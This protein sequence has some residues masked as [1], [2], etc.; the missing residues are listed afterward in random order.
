MK[1]LIQL[2]N[3]IHLIIEKHEYIRK[4]KGDNYNLFKVINMTSDETRVHSAMIADLLNP[5]GQHQM[6]D[7]FLK[8]FI[9]RLNGQTDHIVSFTC[10]NA[11]VECEKYIGPKTD[12]DGGRLDIYL[13]DGI[14]HIVIENK[15]YATDQENQLLRY[16]NFLKR[17]SKNKNDTL[18]LYLSLDGE[19][20]DID[21]T[22]GG[23]EIT[24]FTIS[25]ADFIL[26]WLTDC[27]HK[28]IDKSL[29]REGIAHYLNLIKILTHQMDKEKNE[30]INLIKSNP[31]YISCIYNRLLLNIL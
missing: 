3:E 11:K 19:V 21:K 1:K 26:N 30:L 20:H 14:N 4:E 7:V 22:T 12:T 18:L 5:N 15:I 9:E 10:D 16:H 29:I 6:K 31:K 27:R 17:C 2:F 25:Y 8:L 28:A 23:E 24:F 13:T